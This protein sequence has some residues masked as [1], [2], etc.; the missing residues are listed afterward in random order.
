MS[1]RIALRQ[2]ADL[3]SSQWGM[4]T[5]AQA[6][7]QDV[8]RL[9][10]ARLAGSGDIIR[11]A[12]GVYRN[13]GSPS[14]EYEDLRVAWLST[15]PRRLAEVRLGDQLPSVVAS[16]ASAAWLHHI[17]DLP[18]DRHEFTVPTRRQSQR[19]EIRYRMRQL[20]EAEVTVVHGLPA[21]TP[22]RTIADLVDARTDLTLVAD[23][24]SEAILKET[25]NL[26]RLAEA[27]APLAARNG[28]DQDDGKALR[29][30]LLELAEMDLPSLAHQIASERD[31]SEAILQVVTA[32]PA[33]NQAAARFDSRIVRLSRAAVASA[34]RS[35]DRKNGEGHE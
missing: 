15:D 12:N 20:H 10:L 11:L 30:H 16:G 19:P 27:L 17:G 8:S 22:E 5:T 23:I 14:D 28:F 32:S 9:D 2:L 25:F 6:A 18:A 26:D 29:R 34:Q 33:P 1:T 21:T 24:L 35:T 31:L 7:A 13:A 4:F 3:S